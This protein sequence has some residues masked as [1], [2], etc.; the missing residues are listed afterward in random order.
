MV[1][2]LVKEY[3]RSQP[4]AP[5]HEDHCVCQSLNISK[6]YTSLAAIRNSSVIKKEFYTSDIRQHSNYLCEYIILYRPFMHAWP[7]F[8][9]NILCMIIVTYCMHAVLLCHSCGLFDVALYV[10]RL[11]CFDHC[12][13]FV[14]LH[15]NLIVVLC[16]ALCSV[17]APSLHVRS[18]CPLLFCLP[19]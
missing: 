9:E 10:C 6:L 5:N 18:F 17:E 4:T 19:F 11:I 3:T 1:T 7:L 12:A 14:P 16:K 15:V 8:N 2:Q 13:V